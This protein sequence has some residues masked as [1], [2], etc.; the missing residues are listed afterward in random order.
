[1]FLTLWH[2]LTYNQVDATLASLSILKYGALKWPHRVIRGSKIKSAWILF[3]SMS[4]RRPW[5]KYSKNVIIFQM[6]H[7]V[8]TLGVVKGQRLVF[9]LY[10]GQKFNL[11]QLS[12]K[13]WQIVHLLESIQKKNTLY[14]LKCQ[15]TEIWCKKSLLPL[16]E[17]WPV[18][19]WSKNIWRRHRR[20]CKLFFFWMPL[21]RRTICH[22]FQENRS[23]LIFRPL[24]SLDTN[25]WPFTTP[26]VRTTCRIWKI[27]TF[28]EFLS[29]GRR[30]DILLNKFQALLIFDPLITLW[31]H[32]EAPYFKMLNDAI[33]ASACLHV[34]TCQ[35]VRNS[36]N[37]ATIRDFHLPSSFFCLSTR[38]MTI[39]RKCKLTNDMSKVCP[40][41]LYFYI[42]SQNDW[43]TISRFFASN[44]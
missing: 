14:Y 11:L 1:M 5:L 36:K 44:S 10:R 2:V 7:V 18:T 22:H 33:V 4:D 39:L 35:R 23:N 26:N 25:L 37:I 12:W 13:W 19:L 16:A 21:G 43:W 20:W 6:R 30:S 3:K 9:R 32:F 42:Q 27:I 38:L 8:L 15:V 34:R 24:Y 31:G 17:W 41:T 29:Q 28:L 40:R